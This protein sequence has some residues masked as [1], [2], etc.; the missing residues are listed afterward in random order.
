MRYTF[1]IAP[2]RKPWYSGVEV[3]IFPWIVC[4]HNGIGYEKQRDYSETNLHTPIVRY[5]SNTRVG[6]IVG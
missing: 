4:T 2:N 3:I 1:V 6:V 5:V